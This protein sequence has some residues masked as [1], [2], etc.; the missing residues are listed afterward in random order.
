MAKLFQLAPLP[1]ETN[2]PWNCDFLEKYVSP[3]QK[4]SQTFRPYQNGET[5]SA[6]RCPD[7]F[8]PTSQDAGS[9]LYRIKWEDPGNPEHLTTPTSHRGIASNILHSL[10]LVLVPGTNRQSLNFGIVQWSFLSRHCTTKQD[11]CSIW[12]WIWKVNVKNLLK[13]LVSIAIFLCLMFNMSTTVSSGNM[14]WCWITVLNRFEVD[15]PRMPSQ[16]AVDQVVIAARAAVPRWIVDNS[17]HPFFFG[18]GQ[19]GT[20]H[21]NA[22]FSGVYFF[23]LVK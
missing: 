23:W 19:G 3:V 11:L 20:P 22:S 14:C 16:G 6:L 15:I 2:G 12:K 5:P 7:A 17:R 18:Q 10:Q 13:T 9:W 8:G 4:T 1:V 21:W